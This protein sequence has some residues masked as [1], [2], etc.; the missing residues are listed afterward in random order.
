MITDSQG[1]GQAMNLFRALIPCALQRSCWTGDERMT[2]RMGASASNPA[3]E[4]QIR[5]GS[6]TQGSLSSA[7]FHTGIAPS[8]TSDQLS[9]VVR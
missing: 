6:T 7:G 1:A 9:V 4:P 5:V 2:G 3:G 8:G